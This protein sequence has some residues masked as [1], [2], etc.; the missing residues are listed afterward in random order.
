MILIAESGSTK[1]SW[2]LSDVKGTLINK[3]NTIGFNPYFVNSKN[4]TSILEDSDLKKYKS[5]IK[6]VFFLWGRMFFKKKK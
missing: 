2:I 3:F 1:C 6:Y 5:E 4:I